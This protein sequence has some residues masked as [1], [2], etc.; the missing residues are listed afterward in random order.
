M[1]NNYKEQKN[2]SRYSTIVLKTLNHLRIGHT[3]NT[4]HRVHLMKKEPLEPQ[5]ICRT[6]GYRTSIKYIFTVAE[7]TTKI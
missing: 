6:Y 4:L 5:R 1:S 3:H 7:R 2:G